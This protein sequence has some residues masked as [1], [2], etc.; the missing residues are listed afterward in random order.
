MQQAIAVH[1]LRMRS[2]AMLCISRWMVLGTIP[3]LDTEYLPISRWDGLVS[4]GGGLGLYGDSHRTL[5]NH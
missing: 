5:H 1:T 2:T 3:P 4:R